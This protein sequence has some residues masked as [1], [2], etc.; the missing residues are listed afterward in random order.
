MNEQPKRG[1]GRPR[2]LRPVDVADV[3]TGEVS[4]PQTALEAAFARAEEMCPCETVEREQSPIE[5]A[6]A[7]HPGGSCPNM[8]VGSV[9][10]RWR[11]QLCG[12]EWE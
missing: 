9:N 8:T 5:R 10:G 12:A 2:K 1:R 7:R 3:L 6:R 4:A 11:C